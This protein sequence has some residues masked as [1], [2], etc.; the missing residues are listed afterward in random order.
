[1]PAWTSLFGP[2]VPGPPP[3]K[4][5]CVMAPMTTLFDVEDG[6]RFEAFYA[7]R[8][9]GGVALI[10]LNLQ[11]LYPGTPGGSQAGRL[12]ALNDDRHIP[13]LQGLV[14]GLH[15]YGCLVCA[16]LAVGAWGAPGASL[17]GQFLSPILNRRDDRYGGSLD[18]RSLLLSEVIRAVRAAVRHRV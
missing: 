3:L 15:E 16:Q 6:G 12:L 13:R 1:M 4:N 18:G 7:A 9:R 10:T 11:S 8:A 5:R 17:L 14:V 2:L